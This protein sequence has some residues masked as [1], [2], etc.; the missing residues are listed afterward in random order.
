MTIMDRRLGSERRKAKRF[1]VAIDVEWENH[2]GRMPGTLSDI[3]ANGC[4]VLS[5]VD[6]SDGEIVKIFLPLSDGMKVQ[7]LGEVTNHVYEIG[8]AVRFVD[9]TAAQK[10]FLDKFVA[11]HIGE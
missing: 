10:D 11:M 7:F 2:S 8:F 5:A 6:I 1:S 3:S 9:L 4:F